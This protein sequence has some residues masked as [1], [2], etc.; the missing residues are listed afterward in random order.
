MDRRNPYWKSYT[1]KYGKPVVQIVHRDL[2]N[3]KAKEWEIYYI[4]L[5]KRKCDGGPLTNITEGGDHHPTEYPEV[6]KIIKEKS[7]PHLKRWLKENPEKN[8]V[9]KPENREWMK[10]KDHP[11]RSKEAREKV[12]QANLGKKAS[13]ETRMKQS[14]AK[15]G[16]PSNQPKGYKHSAETI[17]RLK[18]INKEIASRPEVIAKNRLSKLGKR[19][20]W[21]HTPVLMIDIKTNEIVKT[22]ECIMDACKYFGKPKSSNVTSVI[23]GK[24]NQA[25]GH[26]WSLAS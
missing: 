21:R 2:T 4:S 13:V 7:W 17:E 25:F 8:P 20:K 26:R 24:R 16:K 11:I 12:R 23:K 22:F 18:I 6:R 19:N 14:L 9:F 15:K 3:K 10:S 1:N 5:L